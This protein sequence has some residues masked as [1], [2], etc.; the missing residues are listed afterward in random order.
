VA[1]EISY[2][3]DEKFITGVGRKN[4]VVTL[5]ETIHIVEPTTM[6][7]TMIVVVGNREINLGTA[8][9]RREK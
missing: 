4:D 9:F 8:R 1:D 5:R 3:L 7:M 6:A 2:S